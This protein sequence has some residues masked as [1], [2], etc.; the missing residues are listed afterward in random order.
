MSE[1]NPS[2]PQNGNA[3]LTKQSIKDIMAAYNSQSKIQLYGDD[4]AMSSDSVDGV[5][6]RDIPLSALRAKETV[7]DENGN[8]VQVPGA[9]R[10][11]VTADDAREISKAYGR[12]KGI[13]TPDEEPLPNDLRFEDVPRFKASYVEDIPD[14]DE[15]LLDVLKLAIDNARANL[16]ML[17]ALYA[18]L[19]PR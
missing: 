8:V 12:M 3:A 6:G 5:G 17:E 2:L 14:T 16:E 7:T 1:Q 13:E 19:S 4:S 18:A 10:R 9:R 15:G 11:A